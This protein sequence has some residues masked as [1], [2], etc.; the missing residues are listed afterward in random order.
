MI[1]SWKQVVERVVTK[2]CE[3]EE[4]IRLDVVAVD[5]G[6]HLEDSKVH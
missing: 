4:W 3:V 6:V 1:Q 5:D 2:Q